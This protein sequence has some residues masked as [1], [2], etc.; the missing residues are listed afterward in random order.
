[1]QSGAATVRRALPPRLAARLRRALEKPNGKHGVI[2]HRIVVSV[3]GLVVRLTGASI[4][5]LAMMGKDISPALPALSGTGLW[6]LSGMLA[7]VMRQPG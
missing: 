4:T 6:T 3:L 7:A 1:M 5:A 2:A